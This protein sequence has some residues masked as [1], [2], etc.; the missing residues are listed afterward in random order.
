MSTF[1]AD[2]ARAA[3]CPQAFEAQKAL[4]FPLIKHKSASPHFVRKSSATLRPPMPHSA[5]HIYRC[6]ADAAGFPVVIKTL[7]SPTVPSRVNGRPLSSLGRMVISP[8]PAS[9][10]SRRT[11]I[12]KFKSPSDH[13]SEARNTHA[14]FVSRCYS[15]LFPKNSL[16]FSAVKRLQR[17]S[18]G[19]PELGFSRDRSRNPIIQ[20]RNP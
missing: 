11:Q 8:A 4:A 2:A 15:L 14:R 1:A 18:A 7:L 16:L 5:A 20:E 6:A 19:I 13:L 17:Y 3:K 10:D 9:F 12:G